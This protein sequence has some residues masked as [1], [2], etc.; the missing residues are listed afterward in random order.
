MEGR[1]VRS[2]KGAEEKEE[3]VVRLLRGG[4]VW[5]GKA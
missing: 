3:G 2:A 4:L 5:P 1:C